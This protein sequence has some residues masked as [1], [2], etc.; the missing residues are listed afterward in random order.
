MSWA[1]DIEAAV[2]A[3]RRYTKGLE[4]LRKE[5]RQS[6]AAAAFAF[7][8]AARELQSKALS[9]LYYF[10]VLAPQAR[11][12]R[13]LEEIENP[14]AEAEKEALF[15]AT[16]DHDHTRSP[17]GVQPRSPTSRS[18]ASYPSCWRLSA[19][20]VSGRSDGREWR[21]APR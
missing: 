10:G 2:S 1:Q 6:P 19:F 3:W 7:D 21:V 15:F 11:Y 4:T 5:A 14:E 17:V 13:R 12:I 20:L 18:G 16:Y 8:V 9:D